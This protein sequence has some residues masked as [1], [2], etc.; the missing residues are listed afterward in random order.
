MAWLKWA[1][2]ALAALTIP[3]AAQ[4]PTQLQP[5]QSNKAVLPASKV[6]TTSAPAAAARELTKAD[7]DAWLDGFMP[8]ALKAG[9][10]P[11]AVVVVVK[12]GQPLT[13]RGFGYSDVKAQKPVDPETT[14]FRPG[15]VSK[16]F[17]WTA[18]MQQ[19]QA[20]KLDLD[21]DINT[22]LDFKIPPRD[23][24]P[25]TLRN[26]M[27]HTPGFAE[28]AKY[29][30]NYDKAPPPLSK[31]LSRAVPDRIYAPGTM[32][33]YSN[34]GASLAGYIVERV[35]GEPFN[36]Y[37]HNHI[38]APLGM[39]HS[40]FDQPLPANLAPLMSKAYQ[41]GSPDPKPY[42]V[43]GMAPAGAL[44]ASGADM[45]KFMIAHLA[46]GGPLLNPTTAQLMHA[47][48]NHFYK[49]LPPMALG[50]YHEDRNGLNIVGHGGDT[51]FFHSDLHLFLDKNVGLY[52]SMNSIGKGAAGHA[53]REQLFEDFTDRYFPAPEQNLPTLSTAKSHG[54]ALSGHYVSSRAG[55]FNWLR[56]AEILGQTSVSVDKDGILEASTV[57]DPSGAARKWREVAP[58]TWQEVNGTDKLEAVVDGSGHVKMFSIT[59]Y[60][61]II[62]F[63]PAPASLNAGWLLPAAGLAM[64][65]ML[66]AAIGWPTSALVRRRYKHASE[67]SGRP[68]Q[69]HRAARAAGWLF[70]IL[71]VGWLILFTLINKDLTALDDGLDIWMR[72]LQLILIAAIVCAVA[73]LWN[74]WTVFRSPGKHK[75]RTIWAVLIALSAAFLAWFCLDMGLLT[76]SLN[77]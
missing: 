1:L 23:G 41:Y 61:A 43:I 22:Y 21:K 53:L 52:I 33:A 76:A 62:E 50:F 7:V 31:V 32:P 4:S 12:D 68:L 3:A 16:L 24:K 9:G 34:Y 38:L 13:M 73:A 67:L 19:V 45:G 11:G 77:Y 37:I 44:A 15:S 54:Q 57:T 74:A 8:Y 60:A 29:L 65:I 18:V 36:K 10:I 40:S 20:G 70:I 63:L 75:I 5:T 27:T 59:P 26:I 58:W 49:A 46:N 72:L 28:T 25:I 17:T 2:A 6:P 39:T 48:A 66:I 71:A 51:I 56:V 42:E 35:S 55:S 69:L 14:L 47:P 30:I 64:L